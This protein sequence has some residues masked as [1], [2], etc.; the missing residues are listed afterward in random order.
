MV[1]EALLKLEEYNY[2]KSYISY[3]AIQEHKRNTSLQKLF[4]KMGDIIN[5]GNDENSNKDYKQQSVIRD[6]IA[7]EYFRETLFR[8]LPNDIADA[9]RTKA[10]H[11]HDSD[12]DTK[13]TNCCYR[14]I[15]VQFSVYPPYMVT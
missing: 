5:L 8:K 6:T 9:H 15:G 10:I 3:R 12:V 2:A 13:Y 7:G 11:W 14:E 1:V 4:D